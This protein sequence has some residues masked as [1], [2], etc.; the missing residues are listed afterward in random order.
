MITINVTE[1]HIADG[2]RGD[3]ASCPI[4]LAVA[5]I[6]PPDTVIFF[7]YSPKDL[8]KELC[9]FM[10]RF[11]AGESVSP[12]SFSIEE[13]QIVTSESLGYYFVTPRQAGI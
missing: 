8:P 7:G 4:N 6:L 12:F 13:Q 10:K 1:Q 2:V 9:S 3:D 5:Q 11:D